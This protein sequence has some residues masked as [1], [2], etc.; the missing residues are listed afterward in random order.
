MKCDLKAWLRKYF[1]AG[2]L[3]ATAL[4]LSACAGPAL[5]APTVVAPAP[6]QSPLPVEPP[7]FAQVGFASWYG[8]AF[9][10]RRTAS[11]E[12][13]D[14]DDLTAAHRHLP[15]DT[16]VQVTNLNNGRSVVLRINDRGPYVRGRIIDVS[17]AAAKRLD[18]KRSGVVPVLI[19]TVGGAG[20]RSVSVSDSKVGYHWGV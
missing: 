1:L 10:R 11:G 13:F 8:E 7:A 2:S 5:V 4:W 16:L 18:M 17:R 19:E 12:P 20:T 6:V 9:N 3:A 14:M 15:I